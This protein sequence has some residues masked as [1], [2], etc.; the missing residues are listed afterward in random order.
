MK[1]LAI[2]ELWDLLVSHYYFTRQELK[3]LTKING[4]SIETLNK[5]I[6]ARYGY[7]DYQQLIEDNEENW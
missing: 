3:L 1:E 4:Y 2:N 7:R 6:Y 5:A